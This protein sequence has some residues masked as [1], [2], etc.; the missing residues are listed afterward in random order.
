M[1][2]KA[3]VFSKSMNSF[4]G[5][6]IKVV[7]GSVAVG[8][9]QGI[10]YS[11]TREK[12]PLYTMGTA[13]PRAFS[14]GKRGIAGTMIFVVFDRHALI[15]ALG[16]LADSGN[17]MKFQSDKEDVRP[18]FTKA[19]GASSA[20]QDKALHTAS[21]VQVGAI[22]R[23]AE[24]PITK[25]GGDQEVVAPWYADQI[26]PFDIALAAANE[27]GALAVMRIFGAEILNEG[28]GMSVDDIVTEQQHTWV[29]RTILPWTPVTPD[30]V[31]RVYNGS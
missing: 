2:T 3:S 12:A 21:S 9:I 18:D 28:S 30:N 15:G 17:Q 29:A 26:P 27:Y 16:A 10:A 22:T 31:S 4:S 25:V 14:R 7:L 5:V 23:D 20:L 6:D 19:K 8:E 24:L 13:D 1:G 11:I